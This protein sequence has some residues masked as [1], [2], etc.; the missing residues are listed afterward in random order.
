MKLEIKNGF[1]NVV[2]F[3][4]NQDK[5]NKIKMCIPRL[6]PCFSLDFYNKT[7]WYD[8]YKVDQ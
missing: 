3:Y 6:Q 5:I 7:P 2:D 1:Y 8:D 4:S